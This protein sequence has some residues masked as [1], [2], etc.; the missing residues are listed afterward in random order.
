MAT[1]NYLTYARSGRT[2]REVGF[3]CLSLV[4]SP[5]LFAYVVAMAVLGVILYPVLAG[6]YILTALLR[7]STWMSRWE[8]TILASTLGDRIDAPDVPRQVYPTFGSF[9]ADKRAWS[10]VGFVAARGVLGP[11]G[12]VIALIGVLYLAGFFVGLFVVAARIAMLGGAITIATGPGTTEFDPW[13]LWPTI[14]LPLM[15]ALAPVVLMAS[16]GWARMT[17]GIARIAL[18]DERDRLAEAEGRAAKAEAQVRI[19]EELHDSIGHMITMTVVQAGAG[20]LV[21]D[22]D[23][24]FARQALKNIEERGRAAMGELDRIITRLRGENAGRTPL[25]DL[26]DIPALIADVRATGV[27]ISADL[28]HRACGEVAS[29]TGFGVVREAVTNAVKHAPGARVHVTVVTVGDELRVC[30]TNTGSSQQPSS[31]PSGQRGL[32]G[33]AQRVRL[34]GGTF[35][36]GPRADGGF[37]VVATVPSERVTS[38]SKVWGE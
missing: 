14:V 26:T 10:V 24:E 28:S 9:F 5:V 13:V 16:H 29:R 17:V 15:L 32:E 38:D 6:R 11:L 23:P 4:T 3:H 8:R 2:W 7:S 31:P 12:A 20:A 25:P 19:D 36:A 27:D 21:F 33:L 34:V 18:G 37:E 30:V 1:P 22:S 35:T